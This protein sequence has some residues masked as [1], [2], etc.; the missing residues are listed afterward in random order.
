MKSA[1]A[2]VAYAIVALAFFVASG[3]SEGTDQILYS[4]NGWGFLF[5]ALKSG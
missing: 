4:V 5:L 2:A 3:F 1:I